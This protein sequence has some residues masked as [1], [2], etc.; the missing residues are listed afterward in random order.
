M[1][2]TNIVGIR[3]ICINIKENWTMLNKY[4]ISIIN[5]IYRFAYFAWSKQPNYEQCIASIN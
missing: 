1:I 3:D 4:V 5:I 2:S